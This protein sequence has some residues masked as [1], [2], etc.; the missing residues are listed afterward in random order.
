M[1]NFQKN[2]YTRW[3]REKGQKVMQNMPEKAKGKH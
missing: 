1:A 3:L 2:I